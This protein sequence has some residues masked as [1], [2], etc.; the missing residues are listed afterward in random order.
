[1]PFQSKAQER[2]LYSQH[3]DVAAKWQKEYGQ[4]EKLPK[5][6]HGKPE[7]PQPKSPW[8]KMNSKKGEKV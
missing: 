6:K 3:P 1:M 5:Y 4:P 2:F 7:T 8:I